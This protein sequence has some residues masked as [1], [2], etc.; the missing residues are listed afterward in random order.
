MSADAAVVEVLS[1]HPLREEELV[2]ALER[3][4]RA[5]IRSTLAALEA[6]RKARRHVY[7]GQVFWEYAGGRFGRNARPGRRRKP[8]IR[9]PDVSQTTARRTT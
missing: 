5:E 3:F 4:G 1:R 7:R 8:A 9:R 2:S 6:G